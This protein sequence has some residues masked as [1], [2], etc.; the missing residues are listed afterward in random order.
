MGVK[1][2]SMKRKTFAGGIALAAFALTLVATPTA[3]ATT[4]TNN[5]PITIPP[6]GLSNPYPSSITVSG[7]AGPITDIN[8]G[9]DGFTSGRPTDLHVA[10]VAPSGHALQ[11]MG[12]AGQ[13]DTANNVSLTFDDAAAGQLP[14]APGNLT[15]GTFKPTSHCGQTVGFPPPGP[16]VSYG[17]PGP[18]IGG[19][20]TFESVF[21]GLTAIGTWNLY[22]FD[23]VGAGGST[24]IPSWSLDVNPDVTPLSLATPGPTVLPTPSPPGLTCGTGTV[25]NGS[26]CVV[27]K[28]KKKKKKRKKK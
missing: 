25:Q 23:R 2:D 7:T 18:G 21:N 5:T 26:Q 22:A 9:L 16:T 10:L 24:T 14:V 6:G 17:N 3:G 28:K 1:G 13:A 19:A 4:Y 20:A 15:S 11:L 12:C 8:V 27:K